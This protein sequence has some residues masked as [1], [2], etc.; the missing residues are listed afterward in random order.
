[1]IYL[2]FNYN[3]NYFNDRI[4]KIKEIG[5]ITKILPFV[6]RR[7]KVVTNATVSIVKWTNY[8]QSDTIIKGITIAYVKIEIGIREITNGKLT[9]EL[10]LWIG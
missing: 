5:T 2:F 7:A 8:Y 10:E 3:Y 9:I 6:L 1:M 4:T